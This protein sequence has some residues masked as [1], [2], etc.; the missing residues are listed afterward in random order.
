MPVYSSWELSG[1]PDWLCLYECRFYIHLVSAQYILISNPLSCF[2]SLPLIIFLC[3][4]FLSLSSCFWLNILKHNQSKPW[5]NYRFCLQINCLRLR[6]KERWKD[7]LFLKRNKFWTFLY[8]QIV[9]IVLLYVLGKGKNFH[10][11][12]ML[13]NDLIRQ[14]GFVLLP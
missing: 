14:C 12:F 6:E 4:F 8:Y 9:F 10:D 1:I 11:A 13:F 7:L 2:Y 5:T 3:I